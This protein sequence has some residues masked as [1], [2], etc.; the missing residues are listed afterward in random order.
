MKTPG[1]RTPALVAL[2]LVASQAVSCAT[3]RGRGEPASGLRGPSVEVPRPAR[4][5]LD[6]AADGPLAPTVAGAPAGAVLCLQPGRHEGPLEIRKALT[7]WGPRDAIVHSNGV[8]TTIDVRDTDHVR[9]MGFTVD[10]SGDT[11]RVRGSS[12]S[13]RVE[14]PTYDG[15]TYDLDPNGGR[16]LDAADNQAV[17]SE[18]SLIQFVTDWQR[19]LMR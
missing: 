5:D 9:L 19:G 12:T 10:G 7:V 2:A 4:C 14:G 6:V 13:L 1:A 11:F 8:G 16:L 15:N 17:R 18:S 3:N